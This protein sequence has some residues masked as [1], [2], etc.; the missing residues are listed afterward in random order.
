M[1]FMH[2]NGSAATPVQLSEKPRWEFDIV[3]RIDVEENRNKKGD[4]DFIK[5]LFVFSHFV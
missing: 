4:T 1:W 5:Y 2:A 3:N